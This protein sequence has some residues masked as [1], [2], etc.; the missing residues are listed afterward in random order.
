MKKRILCALS[1]LGL[2]LGCESN[3]TSTQELANPQGKIDTLVV[4]DTVVTSR[5][6]TVVVSKK[7]TVVMSR[8]DTV[9]VSKKD[10]VVMSR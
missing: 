3:S 8:I 4:M 2:L 1:I 10:T 9:V 5:I 7:D 6:D